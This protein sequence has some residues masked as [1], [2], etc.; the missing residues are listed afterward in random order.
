MSLQDLYYNLWRRE[1]HPNES[2]DETLER[3]SARNEADR[4][5]QA[6]ERSDQ[7]SQQRANRVHSQIEVNIPEHSCGNMSEVCLPNLT[8][9]PD[10]KELLC[11]NS[12]E[13]KNYRQHIQEYNAALAFASMGTE[14]K[15]PLASVYVVRFIIWFLFSIQMNE[16][17]LAIDNCTYLT[18][19]KQVIDL[20][21]II[22]PA[23]TL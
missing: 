8:E 18:P 22:K 5:R 17:N 11:S 4:L 13:A 9:A 6:R 15:S 1:Q 21:R 7:H 16:T 14:I 23:F 2:F 10:L 3:R 19:V 20:W 12:Q